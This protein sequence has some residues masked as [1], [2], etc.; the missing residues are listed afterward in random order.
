VRRV[1]R[2]VAAVVA[3]AEG[4]D[5]AQLGP[6]LQQ[7]VGLVGMLVRAAGLGAATAFVGQGLW[8]GT[9]NEDAPNEA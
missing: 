6:E 9:L 1:A 4:E 8:D 5:D 2:G 7:A 3:T